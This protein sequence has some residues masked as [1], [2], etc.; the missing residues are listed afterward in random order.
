MTPETNIARIRLEPPA[1]SCGGNVCGCSSAAANPAPKPQAASGAMAQR[2]VL[3][4]ENMDCPTEEALIRKRLAGMAEVGELFFDLLGR[5]LDVRH[6]ADA[7]PAILAA[8]DEIDMHA[9]PESADAAS[10][11]PEA[12]ADGAASW[13]RDNGRL[14][15]GG[16][17]AVGAEL[18]LLFG[19]ASALLPAALALL[20]I[21]LTGI[22]VYRRGWL[23]IRQRTLNINALMSIA[24]TGALL[25]GEWPEAA[26]VMFLFALAEAI[27]AK[28]LQRVHRAVES[29]LA[30]SPQMA[31]VRVGGQWQILPV[32]ELAVGALVRVRPGERIAVDG[33]ITAGSSSVDQ[34]PITGESVPVDKM[35]GDPVYAGT[36]NQDGELQFVA[37]AAADDSTLARIV[38]AVH[39]AQA[40]RAPTQR[41]VDRFA[42][43][44]TPA[45]VALAVG[46]ALFHP[47]VYGGEWL[48]WIYRALVL[49]V[50]ACPCALVISTPVTVVSALTAAAR[51]GILIKGGAFL[52]GGHQLKVLALDKTGTLTAGQP[53]VTDFIALDDR[54]EDAVRLAGALASSS[55]HPVSR[56]VGVYAQRLGALPVVSDFSALPGRGVAGTIEGK[57]YS[58]GNHRHV[59][60]AGVCSPDLEARL[61]ALE[62]QGKTAIVLVGESRALAI[63]AVADAVRPQSVE[64][65]RALQ[66]LGIEPVMLTGD[67][68]HTAQTIA[69]QL[70][71]ERVHSE[72]LPEDKLRV[73]EDLQ[74][75]GVA[76]GMVGDGINDAPA[77]ARADIGFAMAA[78]GTDTAIETANVALMD[79]DPRKLVDFVHWSRATRRILRQNIALAIGLK[80]IFMALAI[81]DQATLWMAVF[82]DMGTSLLVVF[83]GMRLLRQGSGTARTFGRDAR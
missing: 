23:A 54:R 71:I 15:A 22:G 28:S 72:L 3:R 33:R 26:M 78:M 80:L 53:E 5:K 37:T 11:D 24:V 32:G 66:T 74:A 65:V 56:A 13:L 10:S 14:L 39:E 49:L 9:V 35:V 8:L 7:L 83:N 61:R 2:T 27:E 6:A 29:L 17:A 48:T 12:K 77:L 50:V 19:N 59:E 47:L 82:A 52:E 64:A 70:G 62:E 41:F 58:L 25:I 44:Y 16:V 51:N 43:W 45:V 57:R 79:D 55:D 31:T 20:A 69:R 81:A 21:A 4:I 73:I 38:R 30:L 34:S 42:A 75:G 18:A 60:E 46:V 63:F 1:A 76:V 40:S 36:I 67:N 68:R